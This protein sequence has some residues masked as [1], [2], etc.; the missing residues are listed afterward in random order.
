MDRGVE[1]PCWYCPKWEMANLRFGDGALGF[2]DMF[3]HFTFIN[4]LCWSRF[5]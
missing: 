5:S 2:L 1:L 4:A 3:S